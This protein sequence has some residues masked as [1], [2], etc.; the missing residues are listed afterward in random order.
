M[1]FSNINIKYYQRYGINNMMGWLKEKKP[2]SE[3]KY[4]FITQTLDNAWKSQLV[5]N[6]LADYIVLYLEK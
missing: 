5:D 4:E 1:W 3:I 2:K 6:G